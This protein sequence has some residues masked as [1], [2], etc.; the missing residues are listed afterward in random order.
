MGARGRV[1]VWMGLVAAGCHSPSSASVEPPTDVPF[2]VEP[3]ELSLPDGGTALEGQ[4]FAIDLQ[5]GSA[6]P[7]RAFLDTGSSG[8]VL[9]PDAPPDAL[10]AV[11]PLAQ[12]GGY[13]MTFGS[14]I[15][16]T[17]ILGTATV[18]L[19]DRTTASPISIAVVQQ[20]SGGQGSAAQQLFNGYAAIV[21]IGMRNASSALGNPIVQLPGHPAYVVEAPSFGGSRG[22]LRIDPSTSEVAS[23]TMLQLD[24]APASFPA[25]ADGTSAWA[26]NAIPG[27][28][29]DQS[30]GARL[31]AS[32]L[33]DTG[34]PGV[35]LF[36]PGY[37]GPTLL[38][39]GS[40]VVVSVGPSS[41]PLGSFSVTVRST[42]QPGSDA[43]DVVPSGS[44]HI[45]LGT[46]LF[47][48]YDVLFDQAHGRV[49]LSAH[50]S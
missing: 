16:A 5:I 41:A 37:S 8:I 19:G 14:G 18:T 28:V 31:C 1:V 29:A 15:T 44:S 30:S 21:G 9:A 50:G 25:L 47:Y 3:L 32:T 42:P 13:S 26:D 40:Q 46:T 6:Q 36:W 34:D 2:D 45:S 48:R 20:L 43:F 17:G 23:Y 24:S 38:P 39:A 12:S 35:Y 22:T 7:I 33:L 49:G 11:V 10:A 27:C 4:R